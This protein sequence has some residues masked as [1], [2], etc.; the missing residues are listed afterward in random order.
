MIVSVNESWRYDEA[1]RVDQLRVWRNRD[2]T[3]P[4]NCNDRVSIDNYNCI[5]D[6]RVTRTVDQG[7]ARDGD[8]VVC[9]GN[10]CSNR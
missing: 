8:G 3:A 9:M 6:G 1:A 4:S 7:R 2:S 5:L 10:I